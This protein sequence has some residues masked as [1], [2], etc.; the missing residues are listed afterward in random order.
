MKNKKGVI[1]NRKQSILL[2]IQT[3]RDVSVDALAEELQVSPV[4]IRRDLESF[5]KQGFVKRYY[6]GARLIEGGLSEDPGK[7]AFIEH[8]DNINYRRAIAREAA[9]LVEDRDIIFINSSRTAVIVTEY[10]TARHVDVITNNGNSIFGRHGQGVNIILTG[11]AVNDIKRSMVG[12][13]ALNTIRKINATKCIIGVSGITEDGDI[14][15][16]VLQETMVNSLMIEKTSGIKILLADH[17][18][19]GKMNNFIIAHINQFTHLITDELADDA[20]LK[21]L[22]NGQL[23]II[24]ARLK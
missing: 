23:V 20:F 13:F 6:G 10:I 5:E 18:K 24:K 2:K 22:D 3:D 9:A 11:G 12:D 21:K 7:D 4:T 15:T 17:T 19:L 14:S 16:A 8:D 1:A